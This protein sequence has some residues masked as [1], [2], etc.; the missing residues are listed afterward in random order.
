M[1]F[2]HHHSRDAPRRAAAANHV[3]DADAPSAA[4]V[5]YDHFGGAERFPQ[6]SDELMRAVDQADSAAY[7]AERHPAS[8]RAGRS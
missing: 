6:V 4:R 5:V 2:D 8:R 1:V 7:D 3:I